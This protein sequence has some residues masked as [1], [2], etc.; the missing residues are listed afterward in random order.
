MLDNV[1]DLFLVFSVVTA[2]INV[3]G[4]R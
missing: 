1:S 4:K 2:N 3:D